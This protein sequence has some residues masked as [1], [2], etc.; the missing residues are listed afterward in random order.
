[1]DAPTPTGRGRT[2]ARAQRWGLSSLVDDLVDRPSAQGPG[3]AVRPGPHSPVCQER[4]RRL[5]HRLRRCPA[6]HLERGRR[7]LRGAMLSSPAGYPNLPESQMLAL[8][9]HVGWPGLSKRP[10]WATNPHGLLVPLLILGLRAPRSAGPPGL[11][12]SI[13]A[14]MRAQTPRGSSPWSNSPILFVKIERTSRG[15]LAP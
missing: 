11:P 14:R 4:R 12:E 9:G 1:M 13:C 5:R 10:S 8:G 3:V 7:R 2:R 6:S 15:A